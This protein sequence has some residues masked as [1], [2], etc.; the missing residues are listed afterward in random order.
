MRNLIIDSKTHLIHI[1]TTYYKSFN[2]TRAEKTNVRFLS[3]RL[4]RITATYL[5]VF[6][7][8]YHFLNIYHS[9][10]KQISPDLFKN[11]GVRY[12]NVRLSSI[13]RK[14]SL[15]VLRESLTINLYRH[16]IKYIIKTRIINKY[17]FNSNSGS[18]SDLIKDL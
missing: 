13:L 14:E 16:L 18:D 6:L 4:S 3:P 8:L 12:T 5:L 2:I 7:P 10:R 15:R 9:N 11:S 17:S 1:V